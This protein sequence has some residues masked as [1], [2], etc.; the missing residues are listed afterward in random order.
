[1]TCSEKTKMATKWDWMGWNGTSKKSRR[2][3]SIWKVNDQSSIEWNWIIHHF[4]PEFPEIC[5]KKLSRNFCRP[6]GRFPIVSCVF[7]RLGSK[8]GLITWNGTMSGRNASPAITWDKRCRVRKGVMSRAE[9]AERRRKKKIVFN[10]S[11]LPRHC[12]SG[13]NKSTLWRGK[14]VTVQTDALFTCFDGKYFLFFFIVSCYFW[15]LLILI[16]EGGNSF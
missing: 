11:I 16:V 10:P 2:R 7:L 8:T 15:V 4:W 5:L 6:C 12:R 1:M 9:T 13:V 3:N 14:F